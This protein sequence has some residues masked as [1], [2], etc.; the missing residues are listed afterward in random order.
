MP[1]QTQKICISVRLTEEEHRKSKEKFRLAG[2]PMETV[3]RK[4]ITD[5][6]V[7]PKPRKNTVS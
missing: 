1:N 5:L 4:L 6:E 2:L 7:K 3:I